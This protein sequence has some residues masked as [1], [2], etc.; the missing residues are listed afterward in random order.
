M[1]IDATTFRLIGRGLL[2][3]EVTRTTPLTAD[4]A[5]AIVQLGYLASGADLE[6]DSDEVALREQI[7]R[8][9]CALAEIAFESV[10]SPSPLP[11]DTEERMAWLA[12]LGGKLTAPGTRELAYVVV[13]LLAIGDLELAPVESDLLTDLQRVLAISDERARELVADAAAKVTPG[14][15]EGAGGA[16][17]SGVDV[18]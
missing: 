3:R 4:E 11:I 14:V 17:Y 5:I 9:I 1:N 15:G 6:D 16:D 2:Q 18:R 13:Y 8:H 12:K 7:G 10:P